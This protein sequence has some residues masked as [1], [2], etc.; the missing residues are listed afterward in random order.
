MQRT[1]P[2]PLAL[3]SPPGYLTPHFSLA[4][5][6]HSQ[7]AVHLGMRNVPGP[8][9]LANLRR[10]AL[11]LEDVRLLLGCP[12][13]VTSGYRSAVVNRAVKGSKSSA[14]MAG[15]A[16]DFIAPRYGSPLDVA[17][18][19]AGEGMLMFDQLI[20]EVG[21]VHLGLAAAHQAPRREVRHAVFK[22]GRRTAYPLGLPQ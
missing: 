9:E 11:V 3:A 8:D 19:L 13:M 2:D 1:A 16:A 21:W 17:R 12:V 4:E 18:R 20:Y 22:P 14:H 10:L 15:L 5:L 7:R 6:T